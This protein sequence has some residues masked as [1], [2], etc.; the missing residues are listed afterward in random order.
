VDKS[1][2]N[3]KSEWRKFGMA[4]A[5]LLSIIAT[6]LLLKHKPGYYYLFGAG[7]VVMFFSFAA[8]IVIKP[9]FIFFSYTGFGI[10]WVMTR[11]ILVILFYLVMTPIGF[12]GKLFG[13]KF[14]DTTFK[15]KGESASYWIDTIPIS[16]REERVK[17][18][19]NQF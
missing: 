7:G 13:K 15:R 2:F 8:P 6:V 5:V 9:L 19:E 1:K 4:L 14:L 11:V 3:D 12:L 10:G 18:Y 16:D 17:D